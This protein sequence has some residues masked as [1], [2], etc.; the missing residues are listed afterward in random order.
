MKP[1]DD[2]YEKHANDAKYK[3]KEYSLIPEFRISEHM[4]YYINEQGGNFLADNDGLFSITGSTISSSADEDFVKIY[5]NSDFFRDYGK[6]REDHEDLASATRIELKADAIMRFVPYEG[7]Y[8]VERTLQLAQLFSQSYGDSILLTGSEPH[9]RTALTPLFSPGILYNSIKSGLGVSY[10]NVTSSGGFTIFDATGASAEYFPKPYFTLTEGQNRPDIIP[11]EAIIE[12]NAYVRSAIYDIIPHASASLDSIAYYYSDKPNYSMAMNN[13]LASVPDFFVKNGVM[14]SLIS[15]DET[16][17]N[18]FNMDLSKEYRMRIILR[19]SKFYDEYT[20]FEKAAV[21]GDPEANAHGLDL[22]EDNFLFRANYGFAGSGSKKYSEPTFSMYDRPYWD[23]DSK[24]DIIGSEVFAGSGIYQRT[25]SYDHG[26]SAFG[27]AHRP[28]YLQVWPDGDTTD[29][30]RILPW[31]A[32]SYDAFTPPYYQGYAVCDLIFKPFDENGAVFKDQVERGS[33]RYTVQD[34]INNL[35]SSFYRYGTDPVASYLLKNSADFFQYAPGASFLKGSNADSIIFANRYAMEIDSS[36]SLFS[37]IRNKIVEYGEDGR[38]ERVKDDVNAGTRWAIQTKWETPIFD[39]TNSCTP[40]LPASGSQNIGRGVWHNYGTDLSG[41]KGLF[42]QVTD[43]P[44]RFVK[45][46]DDPANNPA[47][48]EDVDTNFTASL[49]DVVGFR[50]TASRIGQISEKRTVSEAIVAIPFIDIHGRRRFF[51]LD[52]DLVELAKTGDTFDIAG[53]GTFS[54][55]QSVQKTI[56]AMRKYVIPPKF[57]FLTYDGSSG[58][59]R[60]EPIAMYFFEFDF[61][62]D[63]EDIKKIWHNVAPKDIVREA[64]VTIGHEMLENELM[65]GFHDKLRWMVFKVKQKGSWNYYEKTIDSRDDQRFQFKFNVNDQL[66]TPDYSYN[67]PYDYMSVVEFAKLE[68]RVLLETE[69]E[70]ERRRSR[71]KPKKAFKPD[72]KDSLRNSDILNRAS[73]FEPVRSLPLPVQTNLAE[74]VALGIFART[75]PDRLEKIKKLVVSEFAS[76]RTKQDAEVSSGEE[77]TGNL[78]DRNIGGLFSD[79]S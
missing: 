7:F 14:T 29:D 64:S 3:A 9:Y 24:E 60:V 70:T 57:D 5:T 20:L 28:N 31:G 18:H 6:I 21:D 41:S 39:Y 78:Q 34:I 48:I 61:E 53:R 46:N 44:T 54:A 45:I 13:F 26:G 15:E 59:P 19:S 27:P 32:V 4:D 55:G 23:Y 62:F 30:Y 52:E 68:A 47:T 73:S 11:F 43:Y 42:L 10:L 79:D 35:T 74:E 71:F 2:T 40:S 58:K 37:T 66:E 17:E 1:I 49:A 67:W 22:D 50:K 75:D 56:Q 8:P 76:S 72:I 36:V 38:V 69:E 51:K 63:R 65:D 77:F 33:R 25:A 12:P 16:N